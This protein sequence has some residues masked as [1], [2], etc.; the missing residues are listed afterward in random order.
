MKPRD[1]W[2]IAPGSASARRDDGVEAGFYFLGEPKPYGCR[3]GFL[4]TRRGHRPNLLLR[5]A[6]IRKFSTLHAAM[7]AADKAWPK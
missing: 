4:D 6:V 2:T 1:G 5:G 7:E 3:K